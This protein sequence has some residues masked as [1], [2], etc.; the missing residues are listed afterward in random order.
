MVDQLESQLD[1]EQEENKEETRQTPTVKNFTLEN[2]DDVNTATLKPEKAQSESPVKVKKAQTL[3]PI[4][5]YKYDGEGHSESAL[6][7][8]GKLKKQLTIKKDSQ[9]IM[10]N[11]KSQLDFKVSSHILSQKVD[12]SKRPGLS[13]LMESLKQKTEAAQK[14]KIKDDIKAK[15]NLKF[16]ENFTE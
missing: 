16:Y 8:M 11:L 15:L 10:N 4:L 3:K 1:R 9:M 5:S 12:I 2:K 7:L 6:N 13:S 14:E